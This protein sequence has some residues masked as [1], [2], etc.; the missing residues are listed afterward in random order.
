MVIPAG[1]NCMVQVA[2]LVGQTILSSARCSGLTEDFFRLTE[3]LLAQQ[4]AEPVLERLDPP[5]RAVV[6]MALLGLVL[7]GL[8]L[9][10]G[11]MLGGHWVRRLARHR[12]GMR[13]RSKGDPAAS[14][15]QRLRESLRPLLPEI[16][17]A[18]TI[19]L[20]APSKET[21]ID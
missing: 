4:A 20:D 19:H 8:F 21:K 5:R 16:D 1:M 9:V 2:R 10:T 3:L 6:I 15:N 18:D 17:P 13:D 11:I 12:P 7:V 14:A